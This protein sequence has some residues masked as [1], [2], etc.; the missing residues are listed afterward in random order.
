MDKTVKVWDLHDNKPSCIA[1]KNFKIGPMHCA[2]FCPDA[3]LVAAVGGNKGCFKLWD[4]K[5]SAAVKRRWAKELE[6]A[7]EKAVKKTEKEA[8][9]A[10]T[11]GNSEK[12]ANDGKGDDDDDDEN[13]ESD[14]DE[15]DD[16]DDGKEEDDEDDDEDDD[17]NEDG[18]EKDDDD[19]DDDA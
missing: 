1:E 19:E 14:E 11:N 5:K 18:E 15:D 13:E 17:D 10:L 8:E 6:V 12:D 3:P 2:Q 7:G 4:A 9:N 16:D